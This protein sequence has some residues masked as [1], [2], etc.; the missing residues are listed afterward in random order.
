[1]TFTLDKPYSD[2]ARAIPIHKRREFQAKTMTTP[3]ARLEAYATKPNPNSP[4]TSSV[5]DVVGE[6]ARLALKCRHVTRPRPPVFVAGTTDGLI[7]TVSNAP[8]ERRKNGHRSDTPVLLSGVF[9]YP[10]RWDKCDPRMVAAWIALTVAYVQQLWPGRVAA[11]ILHVDEADPHLHVLVHSNGLS[12]KPLHPG[13]LAGDAAYREAIESGIAKGLANRIRGEERGRAMKAFLD[14]HYDCVGRPMGWERMTEAPRERLPRTQAMSAQ[15]VRT[16]RD[17]IDMRRVQANVA[18]V[19]AYV[20]GNPVTLTPRSPGVDID[21]L[22]AI[23]YIAPSDLRAAAAKFAATDDQSVVETSN[24]TYRVL[25]ER[26][27]SLLASKP[28][29]IQFTSRCRDEGILLLPRIDKGKVIGISFGFEGRRAAGTTL[30]QSFRWPALSRVLDFQPNR[31][32]HQAALLEAAMIST[33]ALQDQ[34]C[35]V[36]P[37]GE[38]SLPLDQVSVPGD[39]LTRGRRPSLSVKDDGNER[40]YRWKSTGRIAIRETR[41]QLR[42]V[43]AV[44]DVLRLALK[45]AFAKGWRAIR[46]TAVA[47]MIKRFATGAVARLTERIGIAV[48]LVE[49]KS[50][51]VI[52]IEAVHRGGSGR[53]STGATA[54]PK[55]RPAA[56]TLDQV[57]ARPKGSLPNRQPTSAINPVAEGGRDQTDDYEFAPVEHVME[58]TD[59]R[60]RRPRRRP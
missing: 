54:R 3:F 23:G 27:L 9:S 41:S 16:A 31:A 30:G 60:Q 1:M 43:H 17:P 59:D 15:R 47:D 11:V 13:F 28:D 46:I 51:R 33:A 34:E 53:Q 4:S 55:P 50:G 5:A 49:K 36:E 40:I 22:K 58:P 10:D 26:I 19:T 35:I 29:F 24:R 48:Q 14:H 44:K 42:I 45:L 57:P 6:S 8:A 2:R 37:V 12:I 20:Q 56:Q 25:Q 38:A 7:E 21:L 32:D 52:D 18:A 39:V